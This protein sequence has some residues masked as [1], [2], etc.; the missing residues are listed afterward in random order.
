MG[1]SIQKNQFNISLNQRGSSFMM[2]FKLKL[3]LT[4]LITGLSGT[5]FDFKT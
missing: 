4:L 3:K 5:I 2:K 1:N